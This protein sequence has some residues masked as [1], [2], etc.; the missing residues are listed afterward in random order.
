MEIR[1]LDPA[2]RAEDL[3]AALP[4]A[5]AVLAQQ[6]PGFPELPASMLRL[7]CL[8]DWQAHTSVFAAFDSPGAATAD[9]LVIAEWEDDANE[10]LLVASVWVAPHARGRGVGSALWADVLRLGSTLGRRRVTTNT[11][12]ALPV[13]TLVTAKGGRQVEKATRSVLD[14]TAV[15]PV[16]LNAAARATPKNSRYEL[17][18][19]TDRC[20]DRLAESFCAAMEA[21]NDAPQGEMVYEHVAHDLARLRGREELSVRAGVRRHVLAAVTESGQV[22]GF[23]IFVSTPD[24][25]RSLDIWDTGVSREHRGQGLGLRIKAAQT[26]WMLDEFPAADWVQTFNNAENQHMLTINRALG[27]RPA[28]QWSWY[29]FDNS[30]RP[31]TS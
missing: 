5:R 26:L 1:E 11:S 27:Y 29:E 4:V 16:Q 2:H 20:P 25:P 7:W 31:A 6:M 23:S 14:L 21:M 10:D 9:G 3:A 19:W 13:D 12:A 17:V 22:G 24:G 30:A 28:E 15:P 8:P 18:R